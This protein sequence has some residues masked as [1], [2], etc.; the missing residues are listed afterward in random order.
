M[1]DVELAFTSAIRVVLLSVLSFMLIRVLSE[2]TFEGYRVVLATAGFISV[3]SRLGVDSIAFQLVSAK[4]KHAEFFLKRINEI[5]IFKIIAVLAL[6]LAVFNSERDSFVVALAVTLSINYFLGEIL[7]VALGQ[8]RVCYRVRLANSVFLFLSILCL[9]TIGAHARIDYLVDAL[10]ACV[11]IA[12]FTVSFVLYSR[13]KSIRNVPEIKE[14]EEGVSLKNAAIFSIINYLFACVSGPAARNI[15]QI[16]ISR[17]GD[18]SSFVDFFLV[19]QLIMFCISV[20]PA[21]LLRAVMLPRLFKSESGFLG[22]KRIETV[23]LINYLGLLVVMFLMILSWNWINAILLDRTP[24]VDMTSVI[25]IALAV[26]NLS[27]PSGVSAYIQRRQSSISSVYL[28]LTSLGSV[29]LFY[30]G[31]QG[32]EFKQGIFLYFCGSL[33]HIL[34]SAF[35]MQRIGEIRAALYQLV[36]F[37]LNAPFFW[38]LW[39]LI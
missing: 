18:P 15:E 28:F 23:A 26:L 2:E 34:M 10:I 38:Y 36:K 17:I 35:V 29:G 39:W 16:I 22:L 31:V 5:I 30:F 12:E 21:S 3:I 27:D 6:G 32:G 1:K 14:N 4:S 24:K 19:T 13:L 7:L 33:L 37:F 25:V 20:S 8:P 11:V 9:A